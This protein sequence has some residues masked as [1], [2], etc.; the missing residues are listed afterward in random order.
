M[1]IEFLTILMFVLM[2]VL[3]ATGLPIVFC[4]GAVGT[5]F[6]Y[7]FMGPASINMVAVSV[8]TGMNNFILI[9]VPLFI[10]MAY[11]LESSGIADNLY[12]M[13]HYWFGPVRGGLA[14][15]TI[16]ICTIFA[17]MSGLS[18][19]GTLT[20]GLVALPSMFKRGYDRKLAMGAVMGGGALGILIP[21]S[22]P[23]V[24]YTLFAKASVGRLFLAGIFPGFLM[25]FLF[26]VY[27]FIICQLRPTAGPAL[28]KEERA[29]WRPKL[30]SIRAVILP[31]LIVLGVLGSIFAGVASPTEAAAIGVVGA[32]ISAS[33]YRRITWENMKKA[34]HQ[35]LQVTG[36][37]LWIGVAA[38]CFA[39][40]YNGIGAVDFISN[41]V[42]SLGIDRWIVMIGMQISILILG[43]FL[44]PLGIMM[45]TLPVYIP[46]VEALGFDVIWFGVLF[47][48]NLEMGYLTPPFGF[49]LFYMKGIAPPG[50]TMQMIWAA[51]YPFVA[52]QM[53][54]LII[55]MIFPEIALFLPNLI[56]GVG[57]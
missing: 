55:V 35:C 33:I 36:M 11:V 40:V 7:L 18:A 1:S 26:M 39:S 38:I 57:G 27:I 28:P 4:L 16:V 31:I 8:W 15:G 51:A 6:A 52:I 34:T 5:I 54:T 23:F 48:I 10:F 45:I 43:C 50:V 22:V 24:I 37:A 30:V 47:V 20:M 9:A 17:A 32:M 49:N 21:P 19:A 44:D 41:T 29:G 46:L 2:L 56:M 25:A 12:R 42:Q 14:M 3:I 53:I 13:M